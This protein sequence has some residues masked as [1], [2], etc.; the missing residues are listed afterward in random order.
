M[1]GSIDPPC[2]DRKFVHMRQWIVGRFSSRNISIT[3]C[4][5]SVRTDADSIDLVV[6]QIDRFVAKQVATPL[7]RDLVVRFASRKDLV[8][9]NAL[10]KRTRVVVLA[11]AWDV[12]GFAETSGSI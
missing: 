6:G 9:R 11:R 1:S 2:G 10:H 7:D 3:A 5:D 12:E 8:H 4:V